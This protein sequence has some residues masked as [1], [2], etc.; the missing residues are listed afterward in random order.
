MT[1]THRRQIWLKETL[2]PS[3]LVKSRLNILKGSIDVATRGIISI[4]LPR[5]K[6]F[7]DN[8]VLLEGIWDKTWT[9]PER[10]SPG[11]FL[12]LHP[13]CNVPFPLWRRRVSMT[14]L[15]SWKT[16]FQ[17]ESRLWW[18]TEYSRSQGL[19]APSPS[20]I[21]TATEYSAGKMWSCCHIR[22]LYQ[23]GSV[24][25]MPAWNTAHRPVFLLWWCTRVILHRSMQTSSP[26]LRKWSIKCFL[27]I[28]SQIILRKKT[29][30]HE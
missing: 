17:M 22:S 13:I 19:W 16:A 25:L 10:I 6:E 18:Y 26:V 29:S 15:R 21:S 27:L 28:S 2:I 4:R 14:D 20:L 8:Q 5:F 3:V 12:L 1:V 9:A 30:L 11:L 23:M 7:V 24:I